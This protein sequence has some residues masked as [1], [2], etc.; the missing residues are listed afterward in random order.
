MWYFIVLEKKK[1][2]RKLNKKNNKTEKKFVSVLELTS[3]I[4]FSSIK[5]QL[6]LD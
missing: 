3:K 4:N 5:E 6:I 1:K 2:N